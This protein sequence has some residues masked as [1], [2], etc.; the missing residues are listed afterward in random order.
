MSA[1]APIVATFGRQED[2]IASLRALSDAGLD[3]IE[4]YSPMPIEEVDALL[5]RRARGLPVVIFIAAVA[6]G[7]GGFLVQ[8]YGMAVNYP[9]NV[10]G[11]PLNS[12]PAFMTT[13]FELGVLTAI[14][15]GLVSLFA[16]CRFMRFHAPIF[17][18]A[19]FEHVSQ[20]RFVLRVGTRA[21]D[22][23]TIRSLLAKGQPIAVEELA[24]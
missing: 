5:R 18:V 22:R 15:I 4:V 13:T 2:L 23:Q 19:G 16:V 9:L 3:D 6:G 21:L 1:D 20:D 8:Y 17:A 12:W 7:A 24:S 14:L 11:R 10:G